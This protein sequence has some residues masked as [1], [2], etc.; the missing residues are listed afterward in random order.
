MSEEK[1]NIVEVEIIPED[2][3]VT[4]T[5]PV[6][7]YYRINQLILNFFP[8]KDQKHF[9]ETLGEIKD[10]K[11]DTPEAY[12]LKTLM[13]L[14]LIIEEEARDKNKLKKVKIDSTTGEQVTED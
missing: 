8:F 10:G 5:L 3:E 14:Q 7:Y 2:V 11:E 6:S 9:H 4:I 13:S 1:S 12:H